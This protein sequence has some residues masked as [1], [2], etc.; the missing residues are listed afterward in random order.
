MDANDEKIA[1]YNI[2]VHLLYWKG[3]IR[4]YAIHIMRQKVSYSVC[5]LEPISKWKMTSYQ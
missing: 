5:C 2:F 1:P 4:M 3:G